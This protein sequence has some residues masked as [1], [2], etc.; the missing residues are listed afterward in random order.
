M[1]E[2]LRALQNRVKKEE[3]KKKPLVHD[4]PIPNLT[5]ISFKN[6]AVL[7]IINLLVLS[8]KFGCPFKSACSLSSAEMNE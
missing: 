3:G 7:S 1:D 2:R 5:E 4:Y 6:A 8:T